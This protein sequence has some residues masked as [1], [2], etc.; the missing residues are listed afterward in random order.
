M[1]KFLDDF[2]AFIR[3]QPF[4]FIRFSHYVDGSKIETLEH[5]PANRCQN[6]YSVAKLFTATA[7]GM[8]WDRGL[9]RLDEKICDIFRDELPD[10]TDERWEMN[11][12]ETVLTHRAGLPGGFMDIDCAPMQQFTRDY[13]GYLFTHPLAYT[14][15]TESRYSDSASYLL[16]RVVSKIT[17]QKLD[18]FLWENLLWDMEFAEMAWS[19]CPQG[20]PMGATGLHIHSE[21]MVKL[22]ILYLHKGVYN[23]KRYLSEEWC[24]LTLENCYSIDWDETHSVYFKGGMYG[25]KLLVAPAQNRVIA[26]QA[27][28]ANSDVVAEWV[29]DYVRQPV[30]NACN[31]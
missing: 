26:M 28:G 3:T 8:L 14:P 2:E 7:I 20:Y 31:N 6:T 17:G 15:D 19:C 4:D 13:L 23:G 16:S 24:N 25:Q 11:T 21:D 9:L 29:R 30:E 18:D 12:V 10:G 27:F 1:S 5:I 22:G